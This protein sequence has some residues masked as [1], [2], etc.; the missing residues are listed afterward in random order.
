MLQTAVRTCFAIY[1]QLPPGATLAKVWPMMVYP[2]SPEKWPLDAKGAGIPRFD[3]SQPSSN[4]RNYQQLVDLTNLIRN[5]GATHSP[6]CS[7][8][9][10]KVSFEDLFERVKDTWSNYAVAYRAWAKKGATAGAVSDDAGGETTDDARVP[11]KAKAQDPKQW[12][13]SR[14]KAVRFNLSLESVDNF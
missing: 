11:A 1:L 7:A 2:E 13:T 12:K 6:S 9:L 4:A 8:E 14:K 5:H 10:P 3:F